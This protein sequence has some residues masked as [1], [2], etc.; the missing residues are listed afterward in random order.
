M[1]STLVTFVVIPRRVFTL[2]WETYRIYEV[3]KPYATRTTKQ[4]FWRLPAVFALRVLCSVLPSDLLL[5][6]RVLGGG[7]S[8]IMCASNWIAVF[9]VTPSYPLSF[10][11]NCHPITRSETHTNGVCVCMGGGGLCLLENEVYVTLQETLNG[12]WKW[13][14]KGVF[15]L[16]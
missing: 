5:R 9:V 4:L 7:N 10:K 3:I 12:P 14:L 6:V 16:Y 11:L 13:N 15:V 2:R 1:Q 8:F